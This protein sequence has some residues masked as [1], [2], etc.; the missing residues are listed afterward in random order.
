MVFIIIIIIII[1]IVLLRAYH[2]S[3]R[4]SWLRYLCY[5]NLDLRQGIER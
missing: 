5:G 3:S 4:L 1:L 2:N